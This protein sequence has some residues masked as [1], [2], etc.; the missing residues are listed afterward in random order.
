M[1]N[2]V[3]TD[4]LVCHNTLDICRAHC[5]K[6]ECIFVDKCNGQG[7]KFM[8]VPIDPKFMMWLMIISFLIVLLVCSSLVVC[9]ILRAV[10]ASYRL[11]KEYADHREVYF[12]A[13]GRVYHIQQ[14]RDGYT[15]DRYRR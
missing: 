5:D 14:G 6:S 8:C 9:Y 10:R 2:A 3:Y 11:Q 1:G 12:N 7:E 13:P 4:Q 15:S